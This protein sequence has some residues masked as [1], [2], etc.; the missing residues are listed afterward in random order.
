[1]C[2]KTAAADCL[3]YQH[4]LSMNAHLFLSYSHFIS[5]VHQYQISLLLGKLFHLFGCFACDALPLRH[6]ISI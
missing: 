1:M 6:L 4:P 5:P 3:K 2:T